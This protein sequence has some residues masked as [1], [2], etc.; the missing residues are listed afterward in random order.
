MA[1]P[2][3]SGCPLA[4]P[5]T[6][7]WRWPSE[8]K[9]TTIGWA[10]GIIMNHWGVSPCCTNPPVARADHRNDTNT[11]RNATDSHPPPPHPTN[12]RKSSG[13]TMVGPTTAIATHT[14]S[15]SRC[16]PF[17]DQHAHKGTPSNDT[18]MNA[19]TA[20][21]TQWGAIHHVARTHQTDDQS[22]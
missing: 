12:P 10:V 17:G 13:V 22:K 2:P 8:G 14:S 1:A 16:V 19:P 18:G 6:Q 21:Q 11:Q 15:Q 3:L 5:A 9:G 7:N 4:K 20:T